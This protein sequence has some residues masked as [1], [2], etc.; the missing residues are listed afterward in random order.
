MAKVSQKSMVLS[1]LT[2]RGE[3]TTRDAVISLGILCLP[4]RISELRAD[5]WSI[6]TEY[7]KSPS[8]KKY[9]VYRLEA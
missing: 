3:L 9:G 6:S 1:W 2:T 5:G 4:K 8:G 7:R